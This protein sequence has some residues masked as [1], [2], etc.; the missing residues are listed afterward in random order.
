MMT[1]EERPAAHPWPQAP[2]VASRTPRRSRVTVELLCIAVAAVGPVARSHA[3]PHSHILLLASVAG[4]GSLL[5]G[6]V[7]A[8]W[9]AVR[10]LLPVAAGLAV[11]GPEGRIMTL[12][13]PAGLWIADWTIRRR[14]PIGRLEPPPP[15]VAGPVV[16]IAVVAAWAGTAIGATVAPLAI[17]AV[18]VAALAAPLR[19]G[20]V[21]ALEHLTARVRG[22]VGAV[23]SRIV[24]VLLGLIIVVVPWL[25]QR[26]FRVDP[27]IGP[28]PDGSG[29][30]R[31]TPLDVQPSRLWAPEAGVHRRS[32]LRRV[33][34]ALPSVLI[35]ALAVL[36]V[37]LPS[38]FASSPSAG[39]TG[40]P[41]S[42]LEA[43]TITDPFGSKVHDT[44]VP[45]AQRGQA[46]YPEYQAD[47]DW[48]S[49]DRV[50][51]RPLEE[52][53]WADVHTKYVNIV[54]GV[55]QTWAPPPCRGPCPHLT[56][57]I[58]GGSTL[59]G[60]GQR[61]DHTI[62]SELARVAYTHGIRLDVVNRGVNGQLHWSE[63]NRL[64]W[65]LTVDPK[66][67]LVLFYDGVNEIWGARQLDASLRGNT[68]QPEDPTITDI[69]A[70]LAKQPEQVPPKPPEGSL[71]DPVVA[72]LSSSAPIGVMAVERYARSLQMSRTLA[73]AYHL[74]V[75]YFWQPSRFGR[76]AIPGEPSGG[77]Y[78]DIVSRRI[79]AAA[80][81]RVP[82]SVVNLTDVFKGNT[83][84]LFTDDVHHNEAAA[85]II[86]TAIFDHIEAE[87]RTLLASPRPAR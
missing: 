25:A 43:H 73:S 27:L 41:P 47:L 69:E 6:L 76:P 63:A 37:R 34:G 48:I 85:R 58:Y 4:A 8:R 55:R 2:T 77:L 42:N 33:Q 54:G 65:D 3:L 28:G 56:V 68:T 1:T 31:R 11:F 13:I 5:L 18:A 81:A 72:P 74:P 12:W 78:G 83:D 84:P 20:L 9:S 70:A 57:W 22:A 52:Y 14:P 86:A 61:D 53:R 35:L 51:W 67:D 87:V 39:S 50:A 80:A 15:A 29:W 71:T 45:V 59:F 40:R 38:Y 19:P 49:S 26:L 16:A 60:L 44:Q 24:F 82:S 30:I 46:W 21:S 64:A 32:A 79:Y 36:A 75:E 7:P 66:P 62:P 23:F 17:L 10:V